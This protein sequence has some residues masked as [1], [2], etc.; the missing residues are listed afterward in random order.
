MT[1]DIRAVARAQVA[2]K[3]ACERLENSIHREANDH[4]LIVGGDDAARAAFRKELLKRLQA[5]PGL[6]EVYEAVFVGAPKENAASLADLWAVT[7]AALPELGNAEQ[8]EL[9]AWTNAGGPRNRGATQ[10]LEDAVLRIIER[11]RRKTAVIVDDL[12]TWNR[13]WWNHDE[14]WFLRKILQTEPKL[15]LVG[16]S[17]TWTADGHPSCALYCGLSQSRLS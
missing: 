16:I 14:D 11:R 1:N 2:M 17:P 6:G 7:L 4:Q 13:G 12:E 5:S 10:K 8:D 3:F 15:A 9:T